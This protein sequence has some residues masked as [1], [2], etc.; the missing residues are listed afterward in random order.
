MPA[1][2]PFRAGRPNR[3][4]VHPALGRVLGVMSKR[5]FLAVNDYQHGGVLARIYAHDVS[6][7]TAL[8]REPAWQVFL[9]GEPGCPEVPEG[10]S[11]LESDV[12]DKTEWLRKM[13][14]SQDREAE[15]KHPFH[16]VADSG[17]GKE[18]LEVWARSELEVQM[19]YPALQSMMLKPMTG[20][21]LSA[22]RL[23]DIDNPSDFIFPRNDA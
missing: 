13:I 10:I 5:P 21:M 7:V 4:A 17:S 9:E 16:F 15:G 12:D 11:V 19:R 14:Y 22:S 23:C 3:Y 2:R 20:E 18:Y 6:E 1:V 8:L